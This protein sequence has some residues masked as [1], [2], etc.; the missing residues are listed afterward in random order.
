MKK[1][2]LLVICCAALAIAGCNPPA[3]D[4]PAPESTGGKEVGQQASAEPETAAAGKL[5]WA[6]NYDDALKQAKAEDKFVLIKYTAVWCAPCHQM[7]DEMEAT[8]IS[9]DMAKVILVE[10]DIDK[11][12]DSKAVKDYMTS[13]SIPYVVLLDKD[14]KKIADKTGYKDIPDFVGWVKTSTTQV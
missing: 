9:A 10:V 13:P 3:A 8:D 14:G 7:K 2:S 1:W 11:E 4:T 5:T 6:A 12:K